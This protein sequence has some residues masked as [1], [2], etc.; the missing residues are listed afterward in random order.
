MNSDI[1]NTKSAMANFS[2][3]L[4]MRS[5]VALTKSAA[6]ALSAERAAREG[7]AE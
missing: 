2:K 3:R 7:G 4:A 6:D 1:E 5:A